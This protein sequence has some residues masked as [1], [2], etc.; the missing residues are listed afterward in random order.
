[1]KKSGSNKLILIILFGSIIMTTLS[2]IDSLSASYS[3]SVIKTYL[4]HVSSSEDFG[5]N[6]PAGEI[7]AGTVIE[8]PVVLPDSVEGESLCVSILLDS[9]NRLNKTQV[10]IS[11]EQHELKKSAV[12]D[13]AQFVGRSYQKACFTGGVFKPGEATIKITGIDGTPGNAVTAWLTSEVPFGGAYINGK[14]MEHGIVFWLGCPVETPMLN[15][16]GGQGLFCLWLAT[17]LASVV[18]LACF[19]WRAQND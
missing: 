4:A 3:K 8:Q 19:F 12:I 2:V 6:I 11:L 17:Y 14:L 13:T 1:M 10:E 7:I 18:I 5:R 9:Y 16:Y 15:I